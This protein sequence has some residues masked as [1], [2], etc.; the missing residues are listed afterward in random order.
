M[1]TEVNKIDTIT[2]FYKMSFVIRFKIS[3]AKMSESWQVFV[4]L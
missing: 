1:Y 3:V 2:H 4:K